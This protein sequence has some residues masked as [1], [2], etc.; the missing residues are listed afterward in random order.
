MADIIYRLVDM[1]HSVKATVTT[2]PDGCYNVYINARY[3]HIQ[4][5]QAADHEMRHIDGDHLFRD[6]DVSVD[7]AEAELNPASIQSQSS[8]PDFAQLRAKTGYTAYQ[9]AKMVGISTGR[10]VRIEQGLS[11]PMPDEQH[12]IVS[13]FK[14]KVGTTNG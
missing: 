5:Q 7:E 8:P 3:N 2:S 10:Y 1:P 11:Q 4:Q 13:F 12:R 9:V 6:S 14:E